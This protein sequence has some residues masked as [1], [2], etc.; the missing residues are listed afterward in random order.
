MD[1]SGMNCDIIY[2]KRNFYV[3]H[4]TFDDDKTITAEYGGGE[5]DSDEQ[6]IKELKEKITSKYPSE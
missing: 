5:Q 3:V 1:R 4:V 6:K 2:S